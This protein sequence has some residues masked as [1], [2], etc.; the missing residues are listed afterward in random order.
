MT[1]L[2]N[3]TGYNAS[4]QLQAPA[5]MKSMFQNFNT[6]P[7][8]GGVGPMVNLSGYG[9]GAT[10]GT[11]TAGSGVA[12]GGGGGTGAY[13]GG[14]GGAYSA[15][16]AVTAAT[17]TGAGGV[18][19]NLNPSPQAGSGTFG[20]VPG[21][22]GAPPSLWQQG[23]SA[24]PGL[25]GLAGQNTNLIGSQMAGQISPTTIESLQNAAASR[26]AALGQPGNT[27]LTQR[28]G[29]STLGLTSE[30]LQQQGQGNYLGFLG[31]VNNS[32]LQPSLL[33]D[34]AANNATMAAAPNPSQAALYMA[35]LARGNGT[36]TSLRN[37]FAGLYGGGG[38]NPA[39]GG[40]DAGVGV[41]MDG[42]GNSVGQGVDPSVYNSLYG[43]ISG[44]SYPGANQG[45]AGY[46]GD[47]YYGNSDP[48]I[49]DNYFD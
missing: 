44:Y 32:Q 6:N 7:N 2:N 36:S 31:A 39:G 30:Q 15:S 42:Y 29:L 46:G 18:P 11:A 17:G 41:G 9:T 20:A 40:N 38:E 35:Q 22:I 49:G 28:I 37:P 8:A 14:I 13:S 25:T 3:T 24:V 45:S 23:Q 33:T 47:D 10:G 1:N 4:A 34:I 21:A 27:G 12:G 5:W 43:D 26:G 19:F 48:L 16:P